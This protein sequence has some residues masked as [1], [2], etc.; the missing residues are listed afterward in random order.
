MKLAYAL[1]T[2]GLAGY[3]APLFAQD[4]AA[5]S[6]T[7]SGGL[8][9][10]GIADL[11]MSGDGRYVVYSSPATDMVSGDTNGKWDVFLR[12]TTLETTE[13]ISM[14]ASGALGNGDSRYP[15]VS[16]D[17]RYVVFQSFAS[18]LVAGDVNTEADTFLV[19]RSLGTIRLVS[20]ST[21]GVQQNFGSYAPRGC[22]VS[23]DGRYVAWVSLATNLSPFDV[24]GHGDR[25]VYFRDMIAGTT[26]LVSIAYLGD[27]RD[28]GWEPSVSADGTLVSFTSNSWLIHP[29]DS[30]SND[31]V[32]VWHRSTGYLEIAS[33]TA[34]GFGGTGGNSRRSRITPDGRYVVF[35]SSATDLHADDTTTSQDIYLRDRT[36]EVTELV[37]YNSDGTVY[38]GSYSTSS[39]GCTEAAVSAD[40]R[41]VSFHAGRWM[42]DC[43][44][45]GAY[46]RDRT[47]SLTELVGIPRWWWPYVSGD[48]WLPQVTDD[49]SKVL[50]SD[51]KGT[52]EHG[53]W[54]KY[55]ASFRLRDTSKNSVHMRHPSAVWW[56]SSIYISASCA[57]ADATY[58]ILRSF[59][60]TGFSYAGAS[61]DLGPQYSIVHRGKIG[62]DGKLGWSSPPIPQGAA[63]RTLYLEMAVFQSDGTV[64][65]SNHT[66]LK[67]IG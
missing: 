23:D 18:N 33:Q 13:L 4:Y 26:S 12:D 43:E 56:G 9:D 62:L 61:F 40:G 38:A 47:D 25:D 37:S 22:D 1:M 54:G 53:T 67:I 39:P 16:E 28:G 57:E 3:A 2:L 46:L 7:S 20:V 52:P 14:S 31:D 21:L 8:P 19:D 6:E 34:A 24:F 42:T 15:E 44:A 5:V 11:A 17:G 30:D 45:T 59:A 50:I 32:F 55:V 65:D 10:E 41:Y 27:Q 36:T 51:D 64:S 58:V 49:G 66:E 60:R 63:G 48:G 29:D 35:E